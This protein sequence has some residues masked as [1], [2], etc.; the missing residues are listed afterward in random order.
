M[1]RMTEEEADALDELWTKT[2]P[3]LKQG[4]GGF[5]T[6]QRGLLAALDRVSAEYI[7]SRAES[8]GTSPAE[9]IAKMVRKEI[10]ASA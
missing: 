4:S 5:F 1:A 3:P 6:R 10:A 9:I 8:D 7:C 2:T